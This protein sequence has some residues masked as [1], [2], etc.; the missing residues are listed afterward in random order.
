MT[1]YPFY[2]VNNA[3]WTIG[4]GSGTTRWQ[5]DGTNRTGATQ[6]QV[7][8]RMDPCADGVMNFDEAAVDCGGSCDPC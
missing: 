2:H 7:W 3:Y 5:V 8:V 4:T 6:H 1:N